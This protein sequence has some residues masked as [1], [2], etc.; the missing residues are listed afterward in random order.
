MTAIRTFEL[1]FAAA[2]LS[3][4]AAQSATFGDLSGGGSGSQ[5]QGRGPYSA[6]PSTA[7]PYAVGPN[8]AASQY[9]FGGAGYGAGPYAPSGYGYGG[10]PQISGGPEGV[11]PPD[12]GGPAGA[13]MPPMPLMRPAPNPFLDFG[14]NG[15]NPYRPDALLRFDTFGQVNSMTDPFNPWGLSTPFMFVPWTTPLSGWTNAQTWNWWR[16]RSGALPHNW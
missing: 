16:E 1:V 8:G 5:D 2:I 13:P 7:G 6:G 15:P 4:S 12:L 11:P 9:G 3:A 10:A 14:P